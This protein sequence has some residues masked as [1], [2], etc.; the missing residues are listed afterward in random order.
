MISFLTTVLW[1]VQLITNK[2]IFF[3]HLPSTCKILTKACIKIHVFC[4][5]LMVVNVRIAE[6]DEV[7]LLME[8]GGSSQISVD[9]YTCRHSKETT[10][11]NKMQLTSS[12]LN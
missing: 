5:V 7:K 10:L 6:G 3:S 12:I 11:S 8:A 1:R 4:E 9:I 2:M